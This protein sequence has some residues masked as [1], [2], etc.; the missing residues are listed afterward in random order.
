MSPMEKRNDAA[1]PSPPQN[2]LLHCPFLL[3]HVDQ[4]VNMKLPAS[5]S[6]DPYRHRI[7]TR[8]FLHRNPHCR[9]VF[10]E[11]SCLIFFHVST[12]LP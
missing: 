7:G 2:H 8:Y 3:T 11:I 12:F 5:L 10:D 6:S 1:D 9:T 4:S